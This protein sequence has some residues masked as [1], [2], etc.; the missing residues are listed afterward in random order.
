MTAAPVTAQPPGRR[1]APPV[2]P[3]ADAGGHA[4]TKAPPVDPLGAALPEQLAVPE[5][6]AE[7]RQLAENVLSPALAELAHAHGVATEFWDWQGRH[8]VV[9]RSTIVAVLSA[10]D[11]DTSSE[12]SIERA[13]A[14]LRIRPWTQVLPDVVVLREG[15]TARVA[16]HAEEGVAVQLEV[17]LENGAGRRALLPVRGAEPPRVVAGRSMAQTLVAVPGDLPLGWHVLRATKITPAKIK[18]LDEVRGQ[19]VDIVKRAMPALSRWCRVSRKA[20]RP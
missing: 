8:T 7:H 15:V 20:S 5:H 17:E 1:A 4:A 3:A 11:V 10:M 13:S 19:I 2:P 12:A 16:A 18:P 14:E 6:L 9:P